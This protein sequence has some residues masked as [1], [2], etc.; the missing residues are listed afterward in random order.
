AV[1]GTRGTVLV[2]MGQLDEGIAL[3]K[4]SM[5]MHP[6]KQGKALN[7][8]H[9]ASGELIRG[10]QEEASKYLATAKVLDPDCFLIAE[11][12]AHI[13]GMVNERQ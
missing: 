4:K 10:N 2:E 9:I 12:E 5:A 6:E 13:A 7:A 8:C 1:I 3:L 11:L